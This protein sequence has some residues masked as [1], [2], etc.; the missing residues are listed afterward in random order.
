MKRLVVVL[1][2]VLISLSTLAAPTTAQPDA[3]AQSIILLIGDGMG[4][5]EIYAADA[6]AQEVLGTHLALTTLDHL[7]LT[8]T[9]SANSP[10]TDS[11]AAGTAIH[12]GWKT[13][14]AAI[15]VL[16]DGQWVDSIGYAA[17]TAGKSVGV[18]TTTHIT[19]ATPATV[20]AHGID[21]GDESGF[22]T[23]LV[24]FAPEVAFGGGAR[25]FLPEEA[26]G[27]RE[28]GR[29]LVDEMI[30]L[31]YTYVTDAT[32]LNAVDLANTN[33]LLGLFKKYHMD[34]EIDRINIPFNEPSLAEMTAAALDVLDNNPA[35]FFVMIE[36]GRIDHAGH[37]HDMASLIWE[38]LAF[39]AAIQVALD[40]Q[41]LHPDV[42]IIVTADHE[43]GGLS[44]GSGTSYTT[45][46]ANLQTVTC[47]SA[48]LHYRI[49]NYDEG[50]DVIARDCGLVF[51]EE[52][53]NR[54]LLYPATTTELERGDLG[55]AATWGEYVYSEIE[56]AMA[57]VEFGSWSHTSIPVITYAVGP[58]AELFTG[59]LD[60][61]DIAQYMAFLMGTPLPAPYPAAE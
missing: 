61:R 31:G 4:V 15:N 18:V 57:G 44:L 17:H 16:P 33:R 14:N 50:A 38:V 28:D 9:Y 45:S 51:D 54:L 20:Y 27:D 43:T 32:E 29:N 6:Y 48:T 10:I 3:H 22:A 41:A 40:Y 25:F 42:L 11:A 39:D 26:D 60:N 7:A 34:Y 30:N 19:H 49:K 36:S 13:N 58:G 52:Q 1:L 24:A 12:S 53:T 47:S 56:E 37:V 35:G 2:V 59:P 23:Q 5:A 8:T 21:R 46:I 55:G